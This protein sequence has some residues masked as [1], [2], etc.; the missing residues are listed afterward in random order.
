MKRWLTLV[1]VTERHPA[2]ERLQEE[3]RAATARAA[4]TTPVADGVSVGESE[5]AWIKVRPPL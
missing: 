5:Y 4:T 2:G 1:F 3:S